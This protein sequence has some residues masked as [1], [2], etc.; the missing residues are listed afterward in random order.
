[1]TQELPPCPAGHHHV[2]HGHED[3]LWYV[4]CGQCSISIAGFRN[5]DEAIR[6]WTILSEAAKKGEL[7]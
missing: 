2:H 5:P 3:D 1:M 7:G 4:A 6:A